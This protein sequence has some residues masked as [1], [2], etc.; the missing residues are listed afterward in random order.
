[1]LRATKFTT[2]IPSA[3]NLLAHQMTTYIN[4]IEQ[5][6]IAPKEIPYKTDITLF[7]FSFD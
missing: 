3:K 1:M 6:Q 2:S 5:L 4:Q 7:G